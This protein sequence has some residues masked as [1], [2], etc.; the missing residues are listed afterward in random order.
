NKAGNTATTTATVF[1]DSLAPQLT[2]TAPP[3]NACI[4]ATQ[5]DVKGKVV[6][7]SITT[8]K[9]KVGE[10]STDAALASDKTFTATIQTPNEGKLT[11]TVEASD[12]VGHISS[13]TI[14]ITIDRTKP[15]IEVTESGKPF[16]ATIINRPIA[17]FVRAVDADT[18]PTLNAK[19][20][21]AQF[22]TGSIIGNEGTHELRV[23]ATDC[24]GHTSDE[25]VIS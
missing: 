23:T 8:V 1:V 4:D 7:A 12:S 20:D 17:L 15:V 9:V 18:R 2:I 13:T 19:L 11:I 16:T 25:R 14:P 24:A 10:T 6:D 22:V 21:G 3:S 5:V